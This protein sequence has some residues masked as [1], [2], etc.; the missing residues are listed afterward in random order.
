MFSFFRRQTDLEIIAKLE[1][2]IDRKLEKVT[3]LEWGSVGYQLN[4]SQQVIGLGLREYNLTEF[5][6]EIT[7]LT[8]LTRLNLH[9]NQLKELPAQIEN[10]T[11]LTELNLT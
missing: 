1:K 4:D 6:L 5:P 11:K 7:Q 10:L 3:K 9:S 2:R 8:N